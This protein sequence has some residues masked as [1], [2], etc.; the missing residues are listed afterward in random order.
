MNVSVSMNVNVNVN[1]K[2][3]RDETKDLRG[4]PD[5]PS[6]SNEASGL[7]PKVC[8]ACFDTA[9]PAW[10]EAKRPRQRDKAGL[11]PDRLS[12][13][14]GDVRCAT[15]R[16]TSTIIPSYRVHSSK[17]EGLSNGFRRRSMSL[18]FLC[19]EMKSEVKSEMEK[20]RRGRR[21]G[22]GVGDDDGYLAGREGKLLSR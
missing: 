21:V 19:C 14:F 22:V 10:V 5:H 9:V 2:L 8:S 12:Q 20:S 7:V 11:G 6:L 17:F 13:R 15:T 3:L 18:R 16:I 1:L 4:R